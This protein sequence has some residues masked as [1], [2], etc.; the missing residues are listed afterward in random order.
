M[1][2]KS[3][4]LLTGAGG[5]LGRAIQAELKSFDIISLSRKGGDIIHDLTSSAP[6]LP[7][8]DIVVHCA[9]K[10]HVVPKTEAERKAFFDVNVVGT[11]NLL[12]G[13]E[14]SG[15]LPHAFVL[16]STVAVY[17]VETGVLITE[18]QPLNAVEPYGLSKI[19]AEEIVLEWCA[20]HSVTC[21]ILRLP[22]VAGPNPPGN[23]G[24]MIRAI[25]RGYYFNIDNGGAK[26]SVVLAKDVAAII[27][28]AAAIGGIYNLTDGYHPTFAE[29]A[30]NIAAALGKS[31]PLT[32][33]GTLARLL[34]KIGDFVGRS[35]PLDSR[36]LKIISTDLT[37]DDTKAKATLNW[38]ANAVLTAFRRTLN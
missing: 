28:K 12:K 10:A 26:K 23:L 35:F 30:T 25:R 17:G 34:A 19:Q 24:S 20:K 29:I 8:A 6:K 33:P 15:S 21:T 7:P 13:I 2:S 3:S 14:L 9:G 31:K 11:R 16:I 27:P 36:K 37:F 38:K 5:F 22:L 1:I 32:M 18:Q 4:I